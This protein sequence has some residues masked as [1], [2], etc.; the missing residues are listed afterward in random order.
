MK[1]A[2]FL[3]F[4]LFT[5]T[6]SVI[7]Q[8]NKVATLSAQSDSSTMSSIK[9]DSSNINQSHQQLFIRSID[10]HAPL[11]VIDGVISNHSTLG[12]YP[13]D[14]QSM[15]VIK[16]IKAIDLYGEKGKNGVILITTKLSTLLD[17][18]KVSPA[19]TAFLGT[20]TIIK[21]DTSKISLNA[22]KPVV[23][24]GREGHQPLYVIDGVISKHDTLGLYPND[25]QSISVIK[26][27]KATNLYGEKGKDGV[28]LITTKKK[29]I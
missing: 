15:S 26:G 7:A 6:I 20:T 23:I 17:Q 5:T 3:S 2:L 19:K 12:L 18:I 16:G 14:I 25:I 9:I 21:S 1:R 24:T 4:L 28:I 10:G 27:I 29:T 11:Y 13:N 8:S 22:N